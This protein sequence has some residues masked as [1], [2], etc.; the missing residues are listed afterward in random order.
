MEKQKRKSNN[1]DTTNK[2]NK[3]SREKT[4]KSEKIRYENADTIYE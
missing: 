2:R 3:G 4:I 1:T